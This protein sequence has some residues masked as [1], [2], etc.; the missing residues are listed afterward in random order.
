MVAQNPFLPHLALREHVWQPEERFVERAAFVVLDAA[1]SPWPHSARHV[2]RLVARL[3]ADQRFAVVF[4][5][6]S[7]L[8]FRRR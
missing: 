2:E 6:R 3:R 5:E 7:T 8:V 4:E 1:A